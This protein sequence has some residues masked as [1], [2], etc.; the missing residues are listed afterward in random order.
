MPSRPAKPGHQSGAA[1]IARRI[2]DPTNPYSNLTI[3]QIRRTAYKTTGAKVL[4]L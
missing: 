1:M 4:I 2:A 3:H